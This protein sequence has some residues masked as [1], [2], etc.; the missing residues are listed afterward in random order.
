LDFA[1]IFG[2]GF[3]EASFT[4]FFEAALVLLAGFFAGFDFLAI[5]SYP[6]VIP[7]TRAARESGSQNQISSL[8]APD[9]ASRTLFIEIP[10]RAGARP[11]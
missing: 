10:D 3:F 5:V 8:V 7:G 1:A 4:T 6:L 11:G 2:A 9:S